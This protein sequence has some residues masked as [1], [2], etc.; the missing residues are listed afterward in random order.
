MHVIPTHTVTKAR[1]FKGYTWY[2]VVS[3]KHHSLQDPE[4]VMLWMKHC[5]STWYLGNKSFSLRHGY[6]K[7]NPTLKQSALVISFRYRTFIL[8]VIGDRKLLQMLN[9]KKHFSIL[10]G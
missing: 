7:T 6:E 4:L 8:G 5:S 2:F 1:L 9:N 10:T 3:S